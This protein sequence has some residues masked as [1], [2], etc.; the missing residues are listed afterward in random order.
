MNHSMGSMAPVKKSDRNLFLGSATENSTIPPTIACR[1]D[2]K[3]RKTLSEQA[4][5]PHT[6][7]FE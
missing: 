4:S 2:F 6:A 1:D 3:S 7:I 5:E